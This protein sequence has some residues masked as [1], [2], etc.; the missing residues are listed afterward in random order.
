MDKRFGFRELEE[1]EGQHCG[2]K[3]DD[4]MVN[5][6]F[7][8]CVQQPACTAGFYLKAATPS[9]P[10]SR[11]ACLP[12]S[13]AQCAVSQYRTGSC[14]G[15]TNG[16]ACVEQPVCAES[17][18]LLGATPASAGVCV[19]RCDANATHTCPLHTNRTAELHTV[20]LA[21]HEPNLYAYTCE[22]ALGELVK[23]FLMYD[24]DTLSLE[25]RLKVR[26]EYPTEA[27]TAYACKQGCTQ[28][29]HTC[30]RGALSGMWNKRL[31][32]VD[33]QDCHITDPSICS[34]HDGL[35]SCRACG[36]GYRQLGSKEVQT[37]NVATTVAVCCKCPSVKKRACI[38]GMEN[39]VVS[40]YGC[41]Q[42]R[43]T[44]CSRGF[45]KYTPGT[46]ACVRER[47][48]CRH[49]GRSKEMP[50]SGLVF[51]PAGAG[52]DARVV[53]SSTCTCKPGQDLVGVL[54]VL[55]H[56]RTYSSA[57]FFAPFAHG[58]QCCDTDGCMDVDG[59]AYMT[60]GQVTIHGCAKACLADKT[61]RTFQYGNTINGSRSQCATEGTQCNCYFVTTACRTTEP[62]AGIDVYTV[63][64]SGSCPPP[65]HGPTRGLGA[66]CKGDL[67]SNYLGCMNNNVHYGT[68]AEAWQRCHQLQ[69]LCTYT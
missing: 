9:T 32:P 18:L 34:G 54:N 16:F 61:C 13:N 24:A 46:G 20:G 50:E 17:D 59:D 53:D 22:D 1:T 65:I 8:A 69:P 68:L 19:S 48:D 7:F 45:Y 23:R 52:A 25:Q 57:A 11:R 2:N 58:R 26:E 28:E 40:L 56:A 38:S 14:G 15:G 31:P 63:D 35:Q 10:G 39:T 47:A 6:C 5:D 41:V 49:A 27:A 64:Q 44:N 62:A 29:Q 51:T 3:D 42:Y 66:H 43:C 67:A 36:S 37:G 30:N 4:C 21:S 12:C 33:A 55:E 60:R